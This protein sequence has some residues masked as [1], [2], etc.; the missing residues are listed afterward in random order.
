MWG[1]G[2]AP[3]ALSLKGRRKRREPGRHFQRKLAGLG[4]RLLGCTSGCGRRGQRLRLP[5]PLA[6]PGAP[7]L[8]RSLPSQRLPRSLVSRS[9]SRSLSS[10]LSSSLSFFFLLLLPLPRRREAPAPRPAALAG[11]S[12]SAP[13]P[14]RSSRPDSLPL[15][16]LPLLPARTPGSA[17][18]G[19]GVAADPP[20]ACLLAGA[21]AERRALGGGSGRA[22][23][24]SSL[25]RP[26]L[27]A[28]P[29]RARSAASAPPAAARALGTA[30]TVPP[31]VACLR[32]RGRRHAADPSPRLKPCWRAVSCGPR[33]TD[34]GDRAL[35]PPGARA[36]AGTSGLREV[37]S[38]E[39]PRSE[40]PEESRRPWSP[41]GRR[42]RDLN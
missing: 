2:W 33:G 39:L 8:S 1:R 12:R 15:P 35:R 25:L 29:R 11:R 40:C 17:A 6:L 26:G 19:A 32:P 28:A 34:R 3:G 14:A 7:A 31:A 13:F 41:R 42:A 37:A 20:R 9:L 38:G 23:V 18:A 21:A 10:A 5:R 22:A 16:P 24:S 4:S 30:R 36:A 27:W